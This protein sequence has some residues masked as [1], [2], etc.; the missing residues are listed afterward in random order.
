MLYREQQLKNLLAKG[1]ILVAG[2][3]REGRSS[4]AML[5]RLFPG[6]AFDIAENDE[7]AAS[8]LRSRQYDLV[9]KSPGIPMFRFEG[10]IDLSKIT[11]QTDLFLQ[12]LGDQTIGIT[13]TKGKSTT[14][15]LIYEVLHHHDSNTLKAGNMGIPLFDIWPQ[16]NADTRIVAEFSCHQMENIHRAPHVGVLLNF[17]E[18]HLDHY[19]DYLGYKM[20]KMQIALQQCSGDHFFYCSDNAELA[21][22]VA[23]HLPQMKGTAHS[24][25][26]VQAY[27]AG[28]DKLPSLL[29]GNHNL[30][31]IFVA[32]QVCQLLGVEQAE[33]AEVLR[34]FRGLEHRLELVGTFHGITFYNDSISTI[35]QAAIAAVEALKRVDTLILGGYDRGIDYSPLADFLPSSGV[36][37]IALVGEAGTR[38]GAMLKTNAFNLLTCN[39]YSKIV[40]WCFSN[41]AQGG[42]CLLSP[43]AASY[44][45]FQNFEERGSVFKQLILD[46]R[47]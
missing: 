33:F 26:L 12:V 44:D 42:I 37:N 20:A 9:I 8:M 32:Q 43:A 15:S 35:P 47:P 19:H 5:E 16:I 46:Y 11:S 7:A 31:N 45:A 29:V 25:S 4:L 22:L 14:T 24:Y 38:I 39:E 30:S 41:T 6:R 34:S 23:L 27:Q 21:D 1:R 2:F 13:G 28:T 40:E 18:E 17:F 10:L 36:R 3:G